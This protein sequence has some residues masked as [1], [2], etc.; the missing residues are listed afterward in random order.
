[1]QPLEYNPP[2]LAAD[3]VEVAIT[4]CGI[5]GSDIHAIDSGWGPSPYPLIPGHEIVGTVA[6]VGKDV[7]NVKVGDR[8]GIGAQC[9]ACLNKKGDCHEC[10][11]GWDVSAQGDCCYGCL[12]LGTSPALLSLTCQS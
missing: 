11:L 8:V 9:G 1:M 4:H 10:K 12:R 3:F 7:K 6:A 5:C 2:K